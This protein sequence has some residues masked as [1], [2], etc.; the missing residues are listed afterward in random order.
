MRAYRIQD[1]SI[2]GANWIWRPYFIP[3]IVRMQ[4]G[5]AP[6]FSQTYTDLE[7]LQTIHTYSASVGNGY[8]LF[9]DLTV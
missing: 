3:N 1:P 7:T 8:Y 2:R 6:T 9:F 4:T 5:S